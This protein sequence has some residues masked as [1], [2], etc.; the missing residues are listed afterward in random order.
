VKSVAASEIAEPAQAP[1]SSLSP[2]PLPRPL[3]PFSPWISAAASALLLGCAF[4]PTQW[5]WLAWV[6]LAP[7]FTLISSHRRPLNL[8][9]SAWLGGL[10]FWLSAI[11]WVT[12]A[13]ATAMTGWLVMGTALSVFWPA[14]LWLARAAV[15][16]A[17]MPVWLTAT[18][19]WTGLE[20]V[21]AY[22]CTGFPWYYLAH[23]QYS[24]LPLIQIVEITG[25]LGVSLIVA[26]ANACLAQALIAP[27]RWD[28]PRLIPW[29]TLATLLAVSLGFG[30]VRLLHAEFPKGL[31]VALLQ[32]D[33]RQ[34]YDS[35]SS[36]TP[37]TI[38]DT[39]RDLISQA[40]RGQDGRRP[41]L[42]V[43]PETSFPYY[44]PIIAPETTDEAL[45]RALEQIR[46]KT[47]PSNFRKETPGIQS[48]PQA[49]AD[50]AQAAMIVGAS[51]YEFRQDG[52]FKFNGALLYQPG[53]SPFQV[54]RKIH[55]VPF[56][57]YVPLIK[58]FSW[59]I[60]LTP[61]RGTHVPSLSFGE[62]PRWFNVK[63]TVIATPICFEDTVPQLVR[64]LI[65]EAPPDQE[66][67]LL[68]NISNEGWFRGSSEHQA[69]LA[70]SV[71]RAIE[72]RVPMIRAVNTGISA[73]IDGDGRILASAP[74]AA[75]Q[76]VSSW[77]PLDPRRSPYTILG[78]WVGQFALVV[79]V[80]GLFWPVIRRLKGRA[81]SQGSR[82]PVL[83]I[84]KVDS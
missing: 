24:M 4:P 68:A 76:V 58:T 19:A 71:F 50:Q 83:E 72:H 73:V 53:S 39:M 21:R 13:D 34:R 15:R 10:I 55:L 78:D 32:T 2:P 42:I 65:A 66:V 6:A 74:A 47:P 84:S 5:G 75:E 59:L 27:G 11:Y 54:Y 36:R 7:F 41:D 20:Y 46:D 81:G 33:F 25:T 37:E 82:H 60:A 45:G 77:V 49:W 31:Q 51:V 3:W 44:I 56:G 22:Y 57:E 48:F 69:H 79:V 63:G 9:L 12:Y 29:I 80:I 14:F 62:Q 61:Y 23:S 8:Y 26:L 1:A 35:H 70:T 43:W 18:L 64:R 38:L 67:G 17:N 28:R 52:L 16:N 30:A 40:V